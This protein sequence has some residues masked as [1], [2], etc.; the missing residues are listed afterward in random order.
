MHF[1]TYSSHELPLV[2]LLQSTQLQN[3]S[4]MFQPVTILQELSDEGE[5]GI[6]Q[7]VLISGRDPISIFWAHWLIRVSPD[8]CV[9]TE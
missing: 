6:I 7:A 9:V 8:K 3:N 1:F 5:P 2:A 4:G